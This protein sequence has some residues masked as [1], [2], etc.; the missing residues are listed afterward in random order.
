M[1]ACS[2][3]ACKPA[4]TAL[5]VA[6]LECTLGRMLSDTCDTVW[7]VCCCCCVQEARVLRATIIQNHAAAL[8]NMK[9]LSSG[10][11][12]FWELQPGGDDPMERF[13]EFGVSNLLQLNCALCSVRITRVLTHAI[14]PPVFAAVG[15]QLPQ[16]CPWHPGQQVLRSRGAARLQQTLR[17]SERTSQFRRV[18]EQ[19]RAAD[20]TVCVECQ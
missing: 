8:A 15:Q 3:G 7:G 18:H 5:T 4:V 1:R 9:E 11:K 17:G 6:M 19:Q 16:E 12:Q 14:C 20:L 10:F 13:K 2:G